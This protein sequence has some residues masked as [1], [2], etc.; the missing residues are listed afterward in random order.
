MRDIMTNY[1]IS[2]AWE[3]AN[4][5]PRNRH[6]HPGYDFRHDTPEELVEKGRKVGNSWTRIERQMIMVANDSKFTEAERANA[7]AAKEI[8]KRRVHKKKLAYA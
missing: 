2:E 3:H 4:A 5:H 1:G 8:A 6:M 7:N